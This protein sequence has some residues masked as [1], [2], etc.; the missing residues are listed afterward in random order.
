MML[1]AYEVLRRTGKLRDSLIAWT[2]KT[3]G[4]K[5]WNNFKLHFRTAVQQLREFAQ[6]TSAQAG[7][8]NQHMVNQ[9]T[10]NV[11]N[12]MQSSDEDHGGAQQFL[13][14]LSQAVTSNQE[15]LSMMNDQFQTL[16][17]QIQALNA[18]RNQAPAPVPQQPGPPLQN[19]T[20]P[21][22]QFVPPQ[23]KE[24]FK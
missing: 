13:Q 8:T 12:L 14:N 24:S 6:E 19:N 23:Q 20:M 18:T 10:E 7:Y 3:E 2:N 15:S 16:S 11:A 17:S 22:Y 5:T 21:Q 4:E 9:I 1:T